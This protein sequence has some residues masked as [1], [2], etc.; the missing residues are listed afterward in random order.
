MFRSSGSF[1]A[2]R[3]FLTFIGA[4][5]LILTG[6]SL[7]SA[8]DNLIQ[9]DGRINQVAHFGGDALYC[10][11]SNFSATTNYAEM[12]D[13]GGFRLL[14]IGG[15]VLWFVPAADILAAIDASVESK[16]T[17]EVASGQGTYGPVYLYTYFDGK[18]QQ[19]VFSGYDEYGKPN[20][21]TFIPCIPVGPIPGEPG[22][23]GEDLCTLIFVPPPNYDKQIAPVKGFQSSQEIPCSECPN[24]FPELNGAKL[25]SEKRPGEVALIAFFC[26][27]Y[28]V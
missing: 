20:S 26:L 12:I 25:L 15:Q 3:F 24:Y 19:F 10:V 13:D 14:D 21:L 16:S 7:T 9:P 23:A 1:A 4:F 5:V 11:D 2:R 17:V 28:V 8:A 22:E 27:E 18:D 6:A